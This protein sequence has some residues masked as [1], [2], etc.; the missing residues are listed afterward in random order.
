MI[1]INLLPDE[2]RRS[3]G[4]ST[5]VFAAML[6]A[7]VLVCSA[8]GW[9]GIVYFGNLGELEAQHRQLDDELASLR[10]RCTYHDALVNE[11]GEYEKRSR[12]IQD[13][14][15]SRMSWT[16]VLDQLIDVVNNDGNTERHMAWY[17]GIAVTKGEA[18]RGPTVLLPGYVQGKMIKKIADLHDD[19]EATRLAQDLIEVS[20]PQ[21]SQE[22]D[23]KRNPP[24]AYFFNM[25]WV[26]KQPKEWVRNLKAG[27]K[28]AAK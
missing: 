20:P 2:L 27:S 22:I 21:G 13:I 26:F 1:R 18:N 6:I 23:P 19:I 15:Q 16:E 5:K 24:E 11:K 14:G 8:F 28:P 10:D 17:K 4:T 3:E 25:K 9:F 12:T 7:V